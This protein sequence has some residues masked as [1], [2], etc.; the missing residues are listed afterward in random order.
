MENRPRGSTKGTMSTPVL[1]DHKTQWLFSIFAY[2]PSKRMRPNTRSWIHRIYRQFHKR[3]PEWND[4]KIKTLSFFVWTIKQPETQQFEESRSRDASLKASALQTLRRISLSNSCTC[5]WP[6]R[7]RD[8]ARG[9]YVRFSSTG[10]ERLA[11]ISSP[12][13]FP[14]PRAARISVGSSQ[15]VHH[16]HWELSVQWRPT[17]VNGVEE[18]KSL[19]VF[20]ASYF[21]TNRRKITWFR[22]QTPLRMFSSLD[23]I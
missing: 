13:S 19:S 7:I 6:T 3:H 1:F 20:S 9:R 15:R 17:G 22:L 12:N 18:P 2:L 21:R 10:R 8:R 14:V 16:F 23:S 4:F 5:G 11:E